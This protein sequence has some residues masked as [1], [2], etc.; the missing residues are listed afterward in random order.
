M[1]V[2]T[3]DTLLGGPRA[4]HIG[5]QEARAVVAFDNHHVDVANTFVNV[6]WS[7]AEVRQPSETAPR[8][9]EV[10]LMAARK[11]ET[12][13]LLCIVRDVEAFDF[14]VA[15]METRAGFEDFPRDWML[16]FCL[17]G[18]GG[19]GIGEDLDVRK[20]LQS[21]D[22]GGVVTVFVGEENRVYVFQGFAGV[23][24]ELA[25]FALREAGVDED[26]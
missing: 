21:F 12:H 19:G 16:N 3:G 26:A 2:A 23:V 18:A 15:E 24:E 25:E 5:L 9:E 17:H 7:V 20:L 1:T 8:N 13:R 14:Q 4:L 10:G 6:L 11:R 22:S